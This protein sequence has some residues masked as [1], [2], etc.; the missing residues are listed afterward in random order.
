[1]SLKTFVHQS[2]KNGT[3]DFKQLFNKNNSEWEKQYSGSQDTI[4]PIS[5]DETEFDQFMTSFLSSTDLNL[6]AST[7]LD[8]LVNADNGYGPDQASLFSTIQ[9]KDPKIAS[10]LQTRRLAMLSQG[11][12]VEV[13][14]KLANADAIREQLTNVL[15]DANFDDTLTHIADAMPT[16]YSGSI[17]NWGD[18]GKTIKS[19]TN[20]LPEN[21][22]YDMSGNPAMIASDGLSYPL[23]NF[24]PA[25]FIYTN[26]KLKPGIPTRGGLMRAVVW[27]YFFKH[28]AIRDRARFLEKFGTPFLMATLPPNDFD[29]PNQR[30]RIKAALKA[31]AS[32]SVGVA[33]AGTEITPINP[34]STGNN[35]DFQKWFGYIDDGYALLIL[36]Q[37][38]TSDTATGMSNG[39]AQADVRRDLTKSDTEWMSK[40]MTRSVA[41]N[42]EMFTLGGTGNV[43]IKI[44]YK[45]A[46]DEKKNAEVVEI[47]D[48]AGWEVKDQEFM[49][50]KFNLPLVKKI[51]QDP[52]PT[53]N[54]TMTDL[55]LADT[56][57]QKE[58][59][60][61]AF[62]SNLTKNTL[63]ELYDGNG[64]AM[65]EYFGPLKKSISD[66]TKGINPDDENLIEVFN[67][68][69]QAFFDSYPDVFNKMEGKKMQDVMAGAFLAGIINGNTQ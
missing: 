33:K 54:G 25:Q 30:A 23:A 9:E 31:I 60:R 57:A 38:A 61:E 35:G 40:V 8:I 26:F 19:F 5:D 10:H 49:Q 69:I 36:G 37:L 58:A 48:K 43:S 7:L 42:W 62:I 17:I 56:T 50:K 52:Q 41:R 39:S 16:G 53:Q 67:T 55:Q 64:E 66:F 18:G 6:K 1:M 4:Q 34:G 27:M 12:Q 68:Q 44:V 32:D 29:N 24:N 3:L 22:E 21:W 11:W 15:T 20:I 51:K 13:N 14:P 63:L 47:L 45:E 46:E 28:Y 65:H 59:E 2:F